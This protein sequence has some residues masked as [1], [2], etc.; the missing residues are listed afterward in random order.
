MSLGFFFFISVFVR[1]FSTQWWEVLKI[2]Y[3]PEADVNVDLFVS[4]LDTLQC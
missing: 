4:V 1:M 3:A 2:T